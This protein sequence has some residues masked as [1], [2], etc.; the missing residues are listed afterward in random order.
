MFSRFFIERPVLANVIALLTILIGAIAF[1]QLPVA[2]YPNIVPPTVQVQARYPGASAKTLMDT[3]ALPIEQQV[4]G[5]PGMLYMQSTSA[6]DGTYSLTVTFDI[7]TDADEAQ[8]LVQNRVDAANAQ[9]P[10]SVQSQGVTVRKRST[11]ILA[12]VTLDA[13]DPEYDSLFLA[14][15]ATINLKDEIARVP[16]VGDVT[17]YGAGDYAMRIWL[18]ADRLQARGLAPSDIVSAIQSQSQTVSGGQIGMPPVSSGQGFQTPIEIS[19]R[20]DQVEQF[21][22]VV[23]K[24]DTETGAITRLRDVARIELGSKSYG[25]IFRVNGKASAS[26]AISQLPEANALEVAQAVESRMSELAKA[27]PQGLTYAVPFNTTAFV[28]AAVESVYATLIE[29][30][31]IVLVVILLF[32]QDWRA[33]LVPAT[34]V[35]VTLIGA[36]AAMAA[37][38]FSINMSTLFALVLAIGIVVDD[39]IVIVEGAA[40]H[41]SDGLK[42]PQAAE[43]AMEELFGPIIGITLV[44]VA[45]FL[46]AAFLPG[47]TGKLYQQFA[48]VIAAT[49]II[50]AVNAITLKPV[51]A[52]LWMRP[53]KPVEQ[54]NFIFRWFDR[55]FARLEDGYTA[56]LSWLMRFRHLVAAFTAVIMALAFVGLSKVPTG[57][58]PL[59]DQGYLVA[60]VQLPPGASLERTDRS[61]KQVQERL[62]EQPG[63]ANV[64]TVAGVSLLDNNAPL[65]SA[66]LAYIVLKPWDERGKSEALLPIYQSISGRLA[67]LDDGMATAIPPPSIQGIGNTGGFTMMVELTDGSGDFNRLADIANSVASEAAKNPALQG[68]QVNANFNTPQLAVNVDRTKAAT[69][70]AAI[71]DVFNALSGYLGSAYVNQFTRFGHTFQVYVQAEGSYR[72][73]A[74][75][76]DR[77]KVPNASGSLVPIS[78]MV[79][80]RETLGPSLISLYNLHPATSIAGRPQPDISSGDAMQFMEKAA[81]NV[82]PAGAATDWTAISYQEK[83]AGNQIYIAFGLA[84]VLVY[85]VLAGQYESWLG[86]LPVIFS[87]PL[88]LAGTV[89]VLLVLGLQNTL[90]TQIGLVLL[91]ALAA[92]NAIL[93][94]EFAR[95]LRI[96]EGKSLL[97]SAVI[98]GKLR[99][100]PILMTSI[101]FIVGM[102]PLVLASGAG[103]SA[104]KSIGIS[105]VSGMLISTVLSIFVVPALFMIFRALEERWKPMPT[106]QHDTVVI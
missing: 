95:E 38:G 54:R 45:V 29:A 88:A 57:F 84:L 40:R 30:C 25:Q 41:M 52:A 26:L 4:N 55:G 106:R 70:G 103:A 102:I 78:S 85:F 79:D 17:V 82:L 48:L 92:K 14:N 15:Y 91:V 93:I 75:G 6:S 99:F 105:V 34:T 7:G 18:D 104:S 44:L 60:A 72:S 96:K 46:P 66:G 32:L 11:S 13:A 101:A 81:A 90:Y 16:G 28:N 50:S 37:L 31:V 2:Q 1:L 12:F 9:L 98:A 36:F 87:V 58:L 19:G 94:V 24:S 76:I 69:L 89:A 8:I 51:Q 3:V 42:G 74:E 59:E 68:L 80:V 47:L 23:V 73:V 39:A 63:V 22:D 21:E 10:N 5:V 64:I 35:P 62:E 97:D 61:L 53:I 100:R 65:P 49:A 20:L 67:N 27:F 33:M 71:G 56:F 83:L 77:L 43:K 86:P